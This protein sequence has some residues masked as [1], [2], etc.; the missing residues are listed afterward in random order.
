MNSPLDDID[1]IYCLAADNATYQRIN[2]KLCHIYTNNASIRLQ[3]LSDNGLLNSRKVIE[4]IKGRLQDIEHYSSAEIHRCQEAITLKLNSYYG[5][6]N[7]KYKENSRKSNTADRKPIT[8]SRA[9]NF[10]S[11]NEM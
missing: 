11:K 3:N 5:Q 9:S 10:G 4:A 7:E 8:Y 6:T 1:L 2:S